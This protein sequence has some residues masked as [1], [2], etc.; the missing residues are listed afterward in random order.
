MAVRGP[1]E[2]QVQR[3]KVL[4]EDLLDVVRSEHAKVKTVVHQQQLE[5]HQAQV[6]YASYSAYAVCILRSYS[7]FLPRCSHN[8]RSCNLILI[9]V[10]NPIT[11]DG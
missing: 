1:D 2:G 8:S 7:S 6:Q 10:C 4:T 9:L 3:A 11:C 5:L